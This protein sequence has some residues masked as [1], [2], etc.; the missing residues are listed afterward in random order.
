MLHQLILCKVIAGQLYLVRRSVNPVLSITVFIKVT[1]E[2]IEV[3]K[4][5]ASIPRNKPRTPSTLK[6]VESASKEF[7]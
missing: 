2:P 7:L 3:L 6:M 4:M 1:E 5:A